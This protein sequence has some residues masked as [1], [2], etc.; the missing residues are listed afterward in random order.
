[1]A[2]FII[3]H[4]NSRNVNENPDLARLD[5]SEGMETEKADPCF[6]AF[7]FSDRQVRDR[8]LEKTNRELYQDR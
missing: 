8:R 2:A 6:H 5:C 1:M 4:E 7:L 3:L